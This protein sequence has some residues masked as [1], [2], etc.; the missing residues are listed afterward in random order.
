MIM[1]EGRWCCKHLSL[2]KEDLDRITY[3]KLPLFSIETIL[4]LILNSVLHKKYPYSFFIREVQGQQKFASQC[5]P[6]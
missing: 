4:L 3:I 1:G 5:S 2:T 6:S